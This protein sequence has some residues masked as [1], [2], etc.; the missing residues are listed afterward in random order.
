M[1]AIPV[2]YLIDE[3][4][5]IAAPVATG[6]ELILALARGAIATAGQPPPEETGAALALAAAATR[7]NGRSSV[8]ARGAT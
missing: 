8:R 1:F 6:P 7:G 2:A 4:G 5:V 3:E